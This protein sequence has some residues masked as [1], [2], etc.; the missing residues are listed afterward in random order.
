MAE[1]IFRTERPPRFERGKVQDASRIGD[2]DI[3]GKAAGLMSARRALQVHFERETFQDIDVEVPRFVVLTT[4]VFD[5]FIKR[6][7]LNTW[8]GSEASDDRIAHAFQNADFPFEFAGDLRAFLEATRVPLAFRSSSLLEDRLAHPFAGVYETKMLPNEHPDPDTRFK[9]AI[10][11]LKYVYASMFFRGAR[12]YLRSVGRDTRD[13]KMAVVVQEVVGRRHDERYYPHVS[14]VA[15]SYNYYAFGRAR[16]E[17]GVVDLALGLGKTIVDGGLAWSYSP[18]FPRVPPPFA[19]AREQLHGTQSRFWA[20]NMGTP[21]VYDPIS[22]VEFL[23]HHE[24][25]AADYDGILPWIASTYD[26]ASDRM[27]PGA[28]DDGPR[29]VNFAPMLE[30]RVFPLNDL[31]RGI[32]RACEEAFQKH[33]EVEFAL[34]LPHPAGERAR[35]GFLQVRPM[36]GA[37]ERIELPD[38]LP[39]GWSAL[40]R[41]ERV[42]GNGQR[43]DLV[44]IVY[45]RPDT[46]DLARSRDAAADLA[47]MDR[48]LQDD[49]RSYLLIGFG[50]F[51][52]SDPWLGIPVTWSDIARARVI[53]EASIPGVRVDPSQGSHFFHN[54]SSFGVSYFTVPEAD[55]AIDWRWLEACEVVAETELVRHVRSPSALQVIVDGRTTHGLILRP[56]EA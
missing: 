23:E 56:S 53:V 50:R 28:R 19:S 8:T 55:Q 49:D 14:G 37:S 9:R 46:F 27:L 51:G 39:T 35:L 40:L 15:R 10:E 12:H 54:L 47:V 32:V 44:D 36:A 7:D 33:V 25:T 29:V 30:H 26:A 6:N 20:V 16:P 45:V 13:E 17:Q 4:E 48:H 24:L 31:V 38:E 34:L 52:S 41:S 43:D 1:E 21:A 22:E 2:G 42:L 11:A 5:V 3:G 18:A